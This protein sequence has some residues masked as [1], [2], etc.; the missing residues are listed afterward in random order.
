[1]CCL[2]YIHI[3][4][5]T[6][7]ISYMY[8]YIYTYTYIY[9]CNDNRYIFQGRRAPRRARRRRGLVA[10]QGYNNDNILAVAILAQALAAQNE[11]SIRCTR[12]TAKIKKTTI[13]YYD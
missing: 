9:T 10:A 2:L 7:I 1:M 13:I 11:P 12:F 8:I 4:Q 6:H 5:D 3:I